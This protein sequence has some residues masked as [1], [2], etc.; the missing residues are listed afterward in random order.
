MKTI[1]LSQRLD[2]IKS[3]N[4]LR[5]SLDQN[6][7]RLLKKSGYL[8][9]PIPN[10]IISNFDDYKCSKKEIKEY[11]DRIMPDGIVL[12]GGNDIGQYPARDNTELLILKVSIIYAIK[13]NSI[14]GG[15]KSL[16]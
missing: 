13:Q 14:K 11:L 6:Y 16:P 8:S 4:E 9:M 10:N 15:V 2:F 7:V 1:V 3:R 5:D 12:T